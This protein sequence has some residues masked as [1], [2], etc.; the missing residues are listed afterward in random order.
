MF[1]QILLIV[2]SFFFLG[3]SLLFAKDF[4][5]LVKESQQAVVTVIGYDEN[6]KAIKFGTGFFIDTEGHLITNY[7]VLTD[8]SS[9]NVKAYNSKVY[10]IK[11]IVA[12]NKA[13]DLIKISV[14]IPKDAYVPLNIGTE[15]PNIAERI[16][17][18]GSPMGLEHTVSEGII[19]AIRDVATIGTIFQISAPISSGSSGSPVINSDG[20]VIGVASFQL[21]KGQNLNFAIPGK[22]LFILNDLK[23]IRP[24]SQ[25]ND[26][27]RSN[28]QQK[29]IRNIKPDFI[30]QPEEKTE[31]ITL[32]YLDK[33][34]IIETDGVWEE[35]G[36]I[37][38]NRHGVEVGYPKSRIKKIEKKEVKREDSDIIKDYV[39]PKTAKYYEK[40][41]T[42]IYEV[43]TDYRKWQ[44]SYNNK[45]GGPEFIFTHSSEDIQ[46]VSS[47]DRMTRSNEDIVDTIM[48]G[49][50]NEIS[51]PKLILSD[52]RM[53][54]GKVIQCLEIEGMTRGIPVTYFG[55]F[56]SGNAG[57]VELVCVTE[58][59]VFKKNK[60]DIIELFSGLVIRRD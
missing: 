1:R 36:M 6:N 27:D 43:W 8:I 7:H 20:N 23:T 3:N 26:S 58:Q 53:V 21:L 25:A 44:G 32:I 2:L 49:V 37:K 60:D 52:K 31:Q 57:T 13:M 14:V 24:I 19:S 4:S 15:M 45:K 11:G 10:P 46:A 17:V 38:F 59:S 51:K 48:S 42:K 9:A 33:G 18:I 54:N 39:K 55:Y 50:K 30:P 28:I 22:Y 16:M 47:V 40:S 5:D 12:E 34:D 41:K 56:W 35:S 29:Q